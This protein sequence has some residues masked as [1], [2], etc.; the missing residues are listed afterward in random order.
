MNSSTWLYDFNK[1]E[2]YSSSWTPN[3]SFSGSLTYSIFYA[4]N[5]NWTFVGKIL[6]TPGARGNVYFIGGYRVAF[7]L[8]DEKPTEIIFET[9]QWKVD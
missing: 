8:K 7:Q 6:V 1:S 2:K 9:K 5:N 4:K 3:V